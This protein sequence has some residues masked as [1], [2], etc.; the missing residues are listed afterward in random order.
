MSTQGASTPNEGAP[1]GESATGSGE[2]SVTALQHM[3]R[4]R[5]QQQQQQPRNDLLGGG[6]RESHPGEGGG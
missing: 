4:Q 5:Q 3:K 2:G 1:T 6:N